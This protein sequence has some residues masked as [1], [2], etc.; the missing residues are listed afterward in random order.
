MC[1]LR[2]NLSHENGNILFLEAFK[3][4]NNTRLNETQKFHIDVTGHGDSSIKHVLD[5]APWKRDPRIIFRA[6]DIE[7][8]IWP[9]KRKSSAISM[10]QQVRHRVSSISAI[11]VSS[12]EYPLF[13]DVSLIYRTLR[14]MPRRNLCYF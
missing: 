13:C 7:D 8:L 4:L 14:K 6:E 1:Y 11:R 9:R 12:S 5:R 3:E 10:I 2:T